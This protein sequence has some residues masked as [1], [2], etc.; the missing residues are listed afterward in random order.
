MSGVYLTR[1]FGSFCQVVAEELKLCWKAIATETSGV[2]LYRRTAVDFD[3][4]GAISSVIA[5]KSAGGRNRLPAILFFL[6]LVRL[7]LIVFLN[8]GIGCGC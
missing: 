7:T 6:V 5:G 3:G 4:A 2:M 1:D 8:W